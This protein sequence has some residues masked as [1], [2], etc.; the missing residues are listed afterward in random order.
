[1]GAPRKKSLENTRVRRKLFCRWAGEGTP[2]AVIE[3]HKYSSRF[4]TPSGV[5]NG[6]YTTPNN[7]AQ[8]GLYSVDCGSALPQSPGL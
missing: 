2:S 7:R 3:N 6:L 5:N 1:M 4:V 8:F